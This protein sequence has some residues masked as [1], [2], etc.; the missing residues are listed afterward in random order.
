MGLLDSTHQTFDMTTCP[1][2]YSDVGQIG[3]TS[4]AVVGCCCGV[5]TSA[6]HNTIKT[7]DSK[8]PFRMFYDRPLSV[9]GVTAAEERRPGETICSG[10]DNSV[11]GVVPNHC[12]YCCSSTG[13]R[14]DLLGLVFRVV[15]VRLKV[16]SAGKK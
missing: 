8:C 4:A 6:N 5:V 9:V 15:R 16:K 1:L 7:T 10:P 13:W 11:F 3:G 14:Q 12:C 2:K